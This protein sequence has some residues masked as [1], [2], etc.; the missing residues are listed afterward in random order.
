MP[1]SAGL[2]LATRRVLRI[3]TGTGL[4]ATLAFGAGWPMA[5]LPVLLTVTLLAPAMPPPPVKQ[6]LVVLVLMTLLCGWGLLL[7][8]VLIFVP[9]AGVLLML[10]GIALASYLAA[11]PRLAIIAAL[12]TIGNTI[13]AVIARQSSAAALA[14][15]QLM[16]MA[17]VIALILTAICHALFPEDAAPPPKTDTAEPLLA[18]WA[19]IRAAIIMAPPVLLALQN[20]GS[21]LM[22]MMKGAL[23]S[24]QVEH[25]Q[26]RTLARELAGSTAVGGAIA[27]AIWLTLQA[28]PELPPLVLLLMLA[29]LAVA[30]PMYGAVASRYSFAFWQNVMVTIILLLGPAVTDSE[31]GD[32][33]LWLMAV[34]L[35]TFL[36]LAVY[37]ATM[38]R[39]LDGWRQRRLALG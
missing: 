38:V 25:S 35:A 14:V 11:T 5:Y 18:R 29:M 21:Y 6:A 20:P 4:A 8:L 12:M 26:T 17:M 19:G 3:T 15:V 24:Q 33:V 16:V 30:R 10:L 31:N 22:L 23:L 13:I 28:W 9:P 39:L 34:R 2:P 27:I 7:G 1:G 32:G 36:A 37:A